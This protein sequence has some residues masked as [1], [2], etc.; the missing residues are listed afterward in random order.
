MRENLNVSIDWT[1]KLQF[2]ATNNKTDAEIIIAV[3]NPD[4]TAK[5]TGTKPKH[6]FLQGLAGCSGGAII[7]L[8]QKMRAEM[9]TKFSMDI[10]GKLTTEH[11]MYFETID[12]T[13]NFEGNT[14]VK[15]I[16]KAVQMSEEQYCGLSYMLRSMAK[17]NIKILLNGAIVEK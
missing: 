3:E 1:E 8:L 11:P 5:I 13:F 17:F 16:K 10:S 14:D 4:K 2:T 7:F 12:M 6:V 9:P 15:M